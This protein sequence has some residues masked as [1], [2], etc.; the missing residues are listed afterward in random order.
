MPTKIEISK[1]ELED[2][3][4]N[5]KLSSI[6][7]S[8]IFNCDSKT[9]RNHLKY[10]NIKTRTIGEALICNGSSYCHDKNYFSEPNSENCYWAGF[11]AA[12][13]CVFHRG[14]GA[15]LKIKLARKDEAHLYKFKEIINFTGKIIQMENKFPSSS[16]EI[17][18]AHQIL[19]DLN[20]NFNIIPRKT[21]SLLPP[22]LEN[23]EHQLSYIVG[24]IDGDGCIGIYNNYLTIS[25]IGTEN[26]CKWTYDILNK[27]EDIKYKQLKISK[28]KGCYILTYS[29]LRTYPI[30]NLLLNHI[31]KYELKVLNRKW[32]KVQEYEKLKFN[33]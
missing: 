22:N 28:R 19:K 8:K 27:F 14:E 18:S 16:I 20:A 10:H 13:G 33:P 26:I 7:I 2:L 4:I 23:L 1:E 29:R 24:L 11:I 6:D 32:D 25:L 15:T 3:Y 31:K 30:A 9:I 12:D 17:F 21:W 5:Q